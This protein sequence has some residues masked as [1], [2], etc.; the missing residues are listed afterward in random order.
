MPNGTIY[1]LLK[2]GER[3]A[4]TNKKRPAADKDRTAFSPPEFAEPIELLGHVE[5]GDI[6]QDGAAEV[7]WRRVDPSLILCLEFG[8]I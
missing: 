1:K 4:A 8:G 5:L 6:E 3:G 2:D 7:D